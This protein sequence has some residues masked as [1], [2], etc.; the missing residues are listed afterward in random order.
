MSIDTEQF[1]ATLLEERERVQRAIANLRGVRE[2]GLLFALPTYAFIAALLALV[3]GGLLELVTGHSHHAVTPH[4]LPVG[5]G[6][7]NAGSVLNNHVLGI[8]NA[9]STTTARPFDGYIDDVH[10]FAA[11]AGNS[12][13]LTQAQ[14]E[15]LRQ[16]DVQNVPEPSA[17]MLLAAG[18]AVLLAFRRRSRMER[19]RSCS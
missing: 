3:A 18:G 13:V 6:T 17:W 14:L 4:P 11:S 12:G 9:G 1:R 7:I 19:V 5:T 8:G 15:T 16:Q 10:V 2:S